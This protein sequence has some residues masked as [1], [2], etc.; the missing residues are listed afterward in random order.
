M[1]T[2][3]CLFKA[4][5]FV[6]ILTVV[7]TSCTHSSRDVA[8]WQCG[9][10]PWEE[11]WWLRW[12]T[13]ELQPDTQSRQHSTP[14]LLPSA[15]P[16]TQTLLSREPWGV[17]TTKDE[18]LFVSKHLIQDPL[19]LL[20]DDGRGLRRRKQYLHW[21]ITASVQ[22]ENQYNLQCLQIFAFKWLF[23]QIITKMHQIFSKY[24]ILLLFL[25]IFVT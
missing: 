24:N 9:P 25:N 12:H 19:L 13:A 7:Y 11:G 20:S 2:K 1:G 8:T 18:P 17:K 10:T 15:A 5:L 3:F 22:L 6:Q 14:V 16:T 23:V 4:F 21:F